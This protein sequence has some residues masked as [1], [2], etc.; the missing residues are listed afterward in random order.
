MEG[1]FEERSIEENAEVVSRMILN[2]KMNAPSVLQ[3]FHVKY[4]N[5]TDLNTSLSGGNQQKVVLARWLSNHP[6]IVLADDPTKGI[7]VQARRDV[8]KIMVEIA[9]K[10][11]AVLMVSSDNDEL[12]NLTSMTENSRLIVMYE[13]QIVKT[14]TGKSISVENIAKASV[15]L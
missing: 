14:L 10:G 4:Q 15:N 1:V 2:K 8:H 3:D 12:V 13:G 5:K 9:N 11:S 7:D 6:L